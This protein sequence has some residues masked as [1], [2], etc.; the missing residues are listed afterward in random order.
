MYLWQNWP[1]SIR[2]K[3]NNTGSVLEMCIPVVW[4][5]MYIW[6]TWPNYIRCKFSNAG[7][8]LEMCIVWIY[9]WKGWHNP[10]IFEFNNV[11]IVRN[12]YKFTVREIQVSYCEYHEVLCSITIHVYM[13]MC[14]II[15]NG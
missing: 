10:V 5:Y 8:V 2:C 11:L 3:F 14:T 12:I 15:S 13:K 6:Q 9:P 7:S 1:N 4:L